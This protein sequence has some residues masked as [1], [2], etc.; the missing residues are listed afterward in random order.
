[1]LNRKFVMSSTSCRV[2]NVFVKSF[3]GARALRQDVRVIVF[4]PYFPGSCEKLSDCLQAY[5]SAYYTQHINL[6]ELFLHGRVLWEFL[7]WQFR[8]FQ[9]S[10]Q[11]QNLLS[12]PHKILDMTEKVKIVIE[13]YFLLPDFKSRGHPRAGPSCY[14]H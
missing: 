9:I 13:C 14:F 7:K 4:W 3:K 12:S 8:K 2:Q 1:M 11:A 6:I 5:K 10:A